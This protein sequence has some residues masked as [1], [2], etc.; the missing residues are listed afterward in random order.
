MIKALLV[1]ACSIQVGICSAQKRSTAKPKTKLS[2]M[3]VSHQAKGEPLYDVLRAITANAK[4][5]VI[6]DECSTCSQPVCCNLNDITLDSALKVVF[7]GQ[8]WTFEWLEGYPVI[9]KRSVKGHLSDENGRGMEAIQVVSEGDTVY[10][11]QHGFFELVKAA[12]NATIQFSNRYIDTLTVRV[13]ERTWMEVTVKLRWSAMADQ[14]IWNDGMQLR[15]KERAPG[16]IA[17]IKEPAF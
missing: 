10:T 15:T 9:Y 2:E 8:P 4:G 16:A 14:E 17:N 7:I 12:C 11:D 3:R 1:L 5:V 6:S 13:R